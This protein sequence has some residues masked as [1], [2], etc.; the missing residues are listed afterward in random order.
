MTDLADSQRVVVTGLG[1]ITPLGLDVDSF[2]E[3]LLEGKNGITRIEAFDTEKYTCKIGGEIKD[4][5]ATN[6]M[7][8]KAA[9]RN[10]RFVHF[11][12][13]ACKEAVARAGL[14][15]DQEDPDRG[16][17]QEIPDG[18]KCSRWPWSRTR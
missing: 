14:D 13:A 6:Y 11:A 10:D 3:G 4:F 17:V 16:S 2:Y 7:D 12:F 1:A 9:R 5:D 8:P 15:M 18:T